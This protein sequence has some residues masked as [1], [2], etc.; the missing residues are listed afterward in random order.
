[1]YIEHVWKRQV[2]MEGF[3][4]KFTGQYEVSVAVL[5]DGALHTKVR[6]KQMKRWKRER[7]I[8][9][10]QSETKG[11]ES[12]VEERQKE[13]VKK[14][15]FKLSLQRIP[16]SLCNSRKMRCQLLMHMMYLGK[17][18]KVKDGIVIPE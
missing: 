11:K 13:N 9:L 2:K 7:Q 8:T 18:N 1:V 15:T 6:K 5:R 16:C 12:E 4:S 10:V 17:H 3:V 14:I